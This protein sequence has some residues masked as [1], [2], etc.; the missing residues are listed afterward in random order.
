MRAGIDH[1]HNPEF[2]TCEFYMAYGRFDQLLTMTTAIVTR[3]AQAAVAAGFPYAGPLGLTKGD[4][5]VVSYVDVLNQHVDSTT[6]ALLRTDPE[7]AVPGLERACAA[8]NIHPKAAK[9]AAAL[10][11]KLGSALVE[12]KI[13]GPTFV[14][15]H[16]LVLSPLAMEHPTKVGLAYSQLVT[17]ISCLSLRVQAGIACHC[18]P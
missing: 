6:M 5:A 15:E 2:S 12:E 18:L 8:L 4:F 3:I 17:A 11:D 10:V 1:S 7:A 9:T 14:T 13:Q 16:P